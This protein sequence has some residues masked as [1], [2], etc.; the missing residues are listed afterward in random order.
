MP[1]RTNTNTAL[2]KFSIGDVVR[3]KV[4]GFRGVIFDVVNEDSNV[5]NELVQKAQHFSQTEHSTSTY[6]R[7]YAERNDH[8]FVAYISEDFLKACT[9][10]AAV[11]HSSVFAEFYDIS[12]EA[13][14][15][16][17]SYH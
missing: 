17:S 8:E 7:I 2:S 10:G 15:N 14:D 9:S 3:H 13:A 4:F 1:M 6:Y 12:D 16:P 11:R 5:V